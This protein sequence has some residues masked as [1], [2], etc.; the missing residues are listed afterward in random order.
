MKPHDQTIT[1]N[2]KLLDIPLKK[3]KTGS[4]THHISLNIS[5]KNLSIKKIR[6]RRLIQEIN[7]IGRVQKIGREGKSD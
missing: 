2:K 1:S 6:L 5:T 3:T 4:K 7:I